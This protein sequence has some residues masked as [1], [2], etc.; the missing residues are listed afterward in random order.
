MDSE[1]RLRAD[2]VVIG[3]TLYGVLPNKKP[4][5]WLGQAK[6][7]A[8]KISPKTVRDGIFGRNLNSNNGRSEVASEVI[9]GVAVAYP[10]VDVSVKF[11]NS[12]LNMCWII[13]L[14]A[15]S[16]DSTYVFAVFN[17]IF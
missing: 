1:E 16:S 5:N 15:S 7:H 12:R 8:T 9:S 2:P 10:S 11:H 17:C 4:A 13:R 3:T 6:S 14:V